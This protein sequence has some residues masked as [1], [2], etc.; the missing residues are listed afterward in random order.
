MLSLRKILGIVLYVAIA[1]GSSTTP[2]VHQ[3]VAQATNVNTTPQETDSNKA[4]EN[5]YS[6]MEVMVE[7][8]AEGKSQDSGQDPLVKYFDKKVIQE[9]KKNGLEPDS[10][11]CK[12]YR[13]LM[14]LNITSE[15]YTYDRN[16]QNQQQLDELN[17][18]REQE[19][20]QSDAWRAYISCKENERDWYR[21]N[22]HNNA[23]FPVIC[24]P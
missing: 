11:E 1:Y 10:K 8:S 4:V 5:L 18:L 21:T 20:L 14:E 7:A 19:R 24:T 2:K 16:Y 9:C 23:R 6:L 12:E 22:T 13:K 17:K 3:E 15:N